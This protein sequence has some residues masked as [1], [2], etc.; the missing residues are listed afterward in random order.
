MA[1][2]DEVRI[3]SSNLTTVQGPSSLVEGCVP[4][5]EIQI[6]VGR[7]VACLSQNAG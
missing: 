3:L 7:A 4:A 1:W 5:H 2:L 6:L